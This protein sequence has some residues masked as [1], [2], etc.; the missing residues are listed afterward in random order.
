MGHDHAGHRPGTYNTAFAVGVGL[1]LAFVVVELVYGKLSHSLAL[2]ADAGHNFSDVIGLVLAWAASVLGR[3]RATDRRTY[4]LRRLSI[5]ASLANAIL[6]LVV[7]GALAWEA[8][9]RFGRLGE[10]AGPTMMVVS[11]VGVAVNAGTALLFRSGGKRDLNVRGAF[12]HLA[13]DALVS[14][15]V[16]ITGLIIWKTG[17]YWLDPAA[18]L[19]VSGII[20]VGTWSF[21][22]EALGLAIDA[23]PPGIDLREVR[24][25][26]TGLEGVVAIHDLHVWAMSTTETA[27]TAHLVMPDRADDAFLTRASSALHDRFEITHIALQVECGDSARGC[28]ASAWACA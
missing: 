27:L 19:I 14:V 28:I 10:V 4:G 3:M 12:L 21:L 26:L 7:T 6:L 9:L 8:I 16:V 18:S 13:A 1:N 24:A 25:L 5:L 23:V 22:R 17:K 15:G 2:V 11:G 20:L